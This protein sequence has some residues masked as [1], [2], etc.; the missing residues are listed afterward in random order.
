[1]IL[2]PLSFVHI[3][4]LLGFNKTTVQP[5]VFPQIPGLASK[6]KVVSKSEETFDHFITDLQEDTVPELSKVIS[7]KNIT[8]KG[9][10]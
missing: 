7:S 1:M 10:E 3:L 8:G 4:K 5:T 2:I 9:S 6:T